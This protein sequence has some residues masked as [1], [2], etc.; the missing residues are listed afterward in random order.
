MRSSLLLL[1]LVSTLGMPYSVLLP[2][3]ARGT[4]HGDSHTLGFL[5][6]A[7]GLGALYASVYSAYGVYTLVPPSLAF[8]LLMLVSGLGFVVSARANVALLAVLSIL[9]AY[10]NP[11]IIGGPGSPLVLPVYLLALLAVGLALSAWRGQPFRVLRP[12]VWWGTVLLGTFW[13]LTAGLDEPDIAL[14]FVAVFWAAVHVELG[15]SARASKRICC[16][17]LRK[18]WA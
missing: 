9:A 14:G 1:A 6:T 3:V 12:L 2:A 15:L 13:T 11:F 18:R 4:L 7:A 10:L 8:V 17:S 5:M 16:W